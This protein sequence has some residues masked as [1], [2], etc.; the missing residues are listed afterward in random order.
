MNF[1]VHFGFSRSYTFGRTPWAGDQLVARPL[2]VHKHKKRTHTNTH[3]NIHASSGI[4]THDPSVRMGEDSS[5]L[6]PR[7][8]RDHHEL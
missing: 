6:R 5:Y 4:R 8:H 2:P 1:S 7:G 3:A